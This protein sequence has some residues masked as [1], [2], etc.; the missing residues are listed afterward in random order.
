MADVIKKATRDGYGEGLIELGK[1][2]DDMIVMDADLAAATKTGAFKKVFP[3]KFYNCGIAE[4]NG[5]CAVSNC[6]G[7]S[8]EKITL[9]SSRCVNCGKL[10]ISAE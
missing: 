10:N 1:T 7:N 5:F 2:R 9:F 4:G 6:S 8:L 3:D